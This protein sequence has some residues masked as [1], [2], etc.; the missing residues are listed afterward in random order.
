MFGIGFEI[1]VLF[2]YDP[3]TQII[4]LNTYAMLVNV[5]NNLA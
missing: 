2:M 5:E 1:L 3:Y 4:V